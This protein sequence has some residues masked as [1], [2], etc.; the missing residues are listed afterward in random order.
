MAKIGLSERA[1]VAAVRTRG[2]RRMAASRILNSGLLQWRGGTDVLRALEIVPPVLRSRDPS[3]WAE[4]ESGYF[5]LAG[6]VAHLNSRSPFDIVAPGP[7]FERE[8]HGFAWLRHL[9][10]TGDVAAQKVARDWVLHWMRSR[11][12]RVGISAEPAVRARRILSLLAHAPF[13]LDGAEP[14]DFDA[15]GRGLSREISSLTRSWREAI[16]GRQ[17]LLA[18]TALAAANLVMSGRQR[19]LD[20]TLRALGLEIDRQI[21]GDGGHVSRN[22]AV[23]MGLLLDWLPLK[24]CFDALNRQPPEAF[25]AAIPRMLTMLRVLKLG[26][27]AIARFNGI[28][29]SDSAELA[30]LAAYD[31]RPLPDWGIAPIS[32][33]ARLEAGSSIVVVDAGPPPPLMMSGDAHAGCLSFEMSARHKLLFV[34]TGAPAAANGDWRAIARATA[35]HSTACLGE[36]SSA[37]LVRHSGLERLLGAVPLQDPANVT[38]GLTAG[39]DGFIFEGS[40]DGYLARLGLIHHRHLRLNAQ[41]TILAGIERLETKGGQGRLKRDVPFAVHFHLHPDTLATRT[42]RSGIEAITIA[43][44]DGQEWR[45]EAAG[46]ALGIDES[47]SF[48]GHAGPRPAVQIVARGA[49]AGVTE[50]RWSATL[51]H[52]PFARPVDFMRNPK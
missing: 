1:R 30:T 13:L 48:A 12:D 40:H 38:A 16:E 23:I 28:G 50:I 39:D 43:L 47:C 22:P 4:C 37:R 2:L 18:L 29:V 44:S 8:L 32:R 21:L 41:G 51:T 11:R 49:C 27:G 5:G 9:E 26:D 3:F 33:Y 36:Q 52:D 10:A 20:G 45:F 35:S 15:L 34:N 46:A 17:R 7:L 19:Q 42:S 6:H 14:G 24:S 31:D 25:L